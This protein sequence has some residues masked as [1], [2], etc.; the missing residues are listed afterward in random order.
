M[1]MLVSLERACGHIYRLIDEKSEKSLLYIRKAGDQEV[2]HYDYKKG[3]KRTVD[4]DLIYLETDIDMFK[5]MLDYQPQRVLAR[6]EQAKALISG[7]GVKTEERGKVYNINQQKSSHT[8]K[9][10]HIY[11]S[12]GEQEKDKDDIIEAGP[13]KEESEREKELDEAEK[14]IQ[15]KTELLGDILNKWR[16]LKG[17]VQKELKKD[18]PGNLADFDLETLKKFKVAIDKELPEGGE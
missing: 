4:Q 5:L 2:N 3:E 13:S 11:T 15:E 7:E 12:D 17:P 8:Q 1:S 14:T 18:Y 16:R 10:E 6:G 9:E